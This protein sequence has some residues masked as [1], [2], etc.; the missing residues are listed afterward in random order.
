MSAERTAAAFQALGQHFPV[1]IYN[2]NHKHKP[3]VWLKMHVK[4]VKQKENGAVEENNKC[5]LGIHILW[6]RL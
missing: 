2:M 3:H 1:E 5:L 6:D 4:E